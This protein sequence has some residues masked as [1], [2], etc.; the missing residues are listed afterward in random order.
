MSHIR[1][2][3]T[4]SQNAD[5]IALVNELTR[6]LSVV[7]GEDHDF[8]NQ[9]NGL[10]QLHHV[11]VLFIDNKPVACGAFKEFDAQSI[12][13]KRMFVSPEVRGKKLGSQVLKELEQWA[14]EEQYTH[15]YLETGKRMPDAIAL[16]QKN[17]YKDIANY[18]PYIG[19][20]NSR[21]F[22]KKLI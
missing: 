10:E 21:C 2:L 4:N 15:S 22:R 6:Y 7:D 1:S 12:E 8:Y 17:D 9:F 13:V 19:I 20:E 14:I 5:F 3:R 16:Y 11:I 18:G